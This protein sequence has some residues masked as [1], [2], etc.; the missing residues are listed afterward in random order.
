MNV[1][2]LNEKQFTGCQIQDL[3]SEQVFFMVKLLRISKQKCIVMWHVKNENQL[4]LF[5]IYYIQGDRI[6]TVGCFVLDSV[7]LAYLCKQSGRMKINR[8]T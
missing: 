5:S 8:L 7:K 3:F 6:M 4:N 2:L 1:D